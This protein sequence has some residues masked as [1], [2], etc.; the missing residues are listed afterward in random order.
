[1]TFPDFSKI[2]YAFSFDYIKIDNNLNL[3]SKI[4]QTLSSNKQ[5]ICEI[6]LDKSQEFSP[7]LTSKK[8]DDGTFVTPSLDDMA[9]FLSRE[10]YN[11][12]K[13]FN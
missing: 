6:F 11:S 2:A 10:E 8:L 12:N 7:K 1:M 13:L 9:P 4:K 3:D 5:I